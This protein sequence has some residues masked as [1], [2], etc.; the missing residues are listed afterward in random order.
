MFWEQLKQCPRKCVELWLTLEAYYNIIKLHIY[1]SNIQI[2]D[3][4]VANVPA[5]LIGICILLIYRVK[6]ENL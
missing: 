2:S 3:F 4:K 6:E 1:L 5:A